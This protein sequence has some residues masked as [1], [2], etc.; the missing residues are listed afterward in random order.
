MSMLHCTIVS[1]TIDNETVTMIFFQTMQRG[2]FPTFLE[3]QRVYPLQQPRLF[4][5]MG[6]GQYGRE[7][8]G[9]QQSPLVQTQLSSP[10]DQRQTSGLLQFFSPEVLAQ[11]GSVSQ[12]PPLPTQKVLTL[13]ELER[14]SSAVTIQ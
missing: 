7:G 14:Q 1:L 12:L 3:H 10:Q 11:A 9:I 13:E 4:Q 6:Q 5:P 2:P 8:T